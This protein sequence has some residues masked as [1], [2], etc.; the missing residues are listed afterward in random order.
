MR[1]F[2]LFLLL[3]FTTCMFSQLQEINLGNMKINHHVKDTS[4]VRNFYKDILGAK[5][6]Q[7]KSKF[8]R[9]YLEFS[10]GFRLNIIYLNEGV[11]SLTEFY[12]GLWIRIHVEDFKKVA[13][14][15]RNSSAKII[16]DRPGNNEIYFQAPGGQVF[17]MG[18][19]KSN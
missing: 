10:N 14:R 19:L 3:L 2:I 9:D 1:Y 12:D 17:R 4:K 16:K 5:L 6:V 11:P 8:P 13:Q 15:I 7:P 18:G